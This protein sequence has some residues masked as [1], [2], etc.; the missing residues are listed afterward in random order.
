MAR[1]TVTQS[2]AVTKALHD[3]AAAAAPRLQ[4]QCAELLPLVEQVIAQTERLAL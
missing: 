1:T 4:Q 3:S 2:R